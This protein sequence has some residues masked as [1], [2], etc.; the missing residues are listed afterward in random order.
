MG[1]HIW[2]EVKCGLR[3]FVSLEA[4]IILSAELIPQNLFSYGGVQLWLQGETRDTL[5]LSASY[6]LEKRRSSR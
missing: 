5:K 2:Q 3:K 1:H 6:N 4:M